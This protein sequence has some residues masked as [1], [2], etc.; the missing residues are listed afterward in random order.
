[1]G[2]SEFVYVIYVATTPEKL[3]KALLDAE[4]TR[5]YWG[6]DNVSDWRPGSPWEHRRNDEA[7]TVD[8]VGEVL[9]SAPPKRL[10]MTWADPGDRTNRS[11]R[12]KVTFELETVADMTRLTVTHEA[13]DVEMFRKVSSGWPRVLSSLKSLLETGNALQTWAGR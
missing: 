2:S 13:L 6:H 3:W 12:S 5:K 7:Q 1:M 11:R 8:V 9:E 4:F 10:V